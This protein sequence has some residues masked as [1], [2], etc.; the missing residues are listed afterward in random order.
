MVLPFKLSTEL[1][2]IK[3]LFIG[4]IV[5][6]FYSCSETNT[7]LDRPCSLEFRVYTATVLNPAGEPADSVDI[8]I[9]INST[10]KTFDPCT[11]VYGDNCDKEG[12]EGYY[13]IF[14][15]GFD[16]EMPTN[17]EFVTVEGSK[18]DLGFSEV[19]TFG[20][21]GCH[22]QKIDGPNRVSLKVN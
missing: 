5:V 15:D 9:T 4:I 7:A 18:G 16:E 13:V 21:D 14:H 10:G 22:V 8:Q 19:F 11:E 6:L 3:S 12:G 2:S 17:K 1:K 20:Y